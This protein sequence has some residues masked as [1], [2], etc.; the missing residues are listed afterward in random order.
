VATGERAAVREELGIPE[1][2]P[3]M[4]MVARVEPQ[5]DFTTF[6]RAAARVVAEIPE[7]R[8]V[9]VGGTDL[10]AEQREHFGEV[11]QVVADCGVADSM[12]FCGFRTDVARVVSAFDLFVLS[13]N[14]E[15][16]PLVLLEALALGK[17]TVATAVD[18]IPEVLKDGVTG[19]LHAHQDDAGL[20]DAILRF[21]RNPGWAQRVAEAGQRLVL[22]RFSPERTGAQLAGLY[23][24]AL[25]DPTVS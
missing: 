14:W 3:L 22:D 20:A 12:T 21:L 1:D 2:A 16:L 13:T 8:F 5:K 9:V 18:G 7:A 24:A 11:Q 6:A 19:L 23:R 10:T 17:P 4:G 25:G 15:G